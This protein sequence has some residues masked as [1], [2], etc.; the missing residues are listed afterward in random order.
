MALLASLRA[1]LGQK[2]ET[3]VGAGVLA[4]SVLAALVYLVRLDRV[5]PVGGWL[6]LRLAPLWA[7]TALLNLAFVLVGASAL[8]HIVDGSRLR[9]AEWFVMSFVLGL[10]AFSLLMFALGALGGFTTLASVLLV[11]VL[12]LLGVREAPTLANRTAEIL[13]FAAARSGTEGVFRLI[14][15]GV[16]TSLLG[17]VYIEALTPNSFNFDASWY[18]VPVAQEYARLG[19]IVP[20]WGDNHRAYPHL[21]SL[22]QTWALLVPGVEPLPVRWMLMLHLE[23]SMVLWRIVGMVAAA[24]WMLGGRAV[25]GLAAGFFLFPAIFIYDQN[26]GGSADHVLGA[27]AVPIFLACARML[28]KLDWRWALVTGVAAGVHV[29]TKYQA[30]YSIAAV[31]LLTLARVLWVL[32]GRLRHR[33]ESGS[34][35]S[36]RALWLAPSVVFLAAL[37]VSAPHFVKNA[38]FYQNPVYPFARS[39]FTSSFDDWTPAPSISPKQAL[40]ARLA[41]LDASDDELEGDDGNPRAVE[42]EQDKGDRVSRAQNEEDGTAGKETDDDD[43][44]DFRFKSRSGNFEPQGEGLIERLVWAHG[45]LGNWPLFTGNRGLTLGRPYMGALFP[46]LLPVLL[47]L[48]VSKR[49]WFGVGY[50][51]LC[52]LAWVLTSPNDRYLLA[53]LT[54]P[55]AVVLALIVYTWRAGILARIGVS[56]LVGLQVV[57]GFDAPFVYGGDRLRDG[58][59]LIKSGYSSADDDSRFRYNAS[60]RQ[61]AESL[62]ED[63]L[64]LG[65]YFKELLG[66]DRATLNTHADIQTYIRFSRVVSLR[67]FWQLCRDRG[68]TH[69]LYPDGQRQPPRIQEAILVDALAALSPNRWKSQGKVIAELPSDP[70]ASTDPYLVLVQGLDEYQDGIYPVGKLSRDNR[71]PRKSTPRPLKKLDRKSFEMLALASDAVVWRRQTDQK[72]MNLLREHFRKIESFG[73]TEIWLRKVPGEESDELDEE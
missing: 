9:T 37:L 51:Y 53:F 60:E 4:A 11:L 64:V 26:I 2:R 68:V 19:R 57:W 48:R 23:F 8:K 10:A 54:I 42:E 65:R 44:L 40:L 49:L 29:L 27:S 18:H 59:A 39:L 46:L 30:I 71:L 36:W 50:S 17:L 24:Q 7:Y 6:I 21:T 35:P 1:F 52:F 43:G 72:K 47:F 20:F 34:L 70:P 25:R 12:C 22:L 73:S 5:Y 63:A 41:E 33:D 32:G 31:A 58:I 62:P 16:F 13:R 61:L 3:F 66:F 69:L 28:R 38:I 15:V 67:D 55:M 45:V 56:L 14:L